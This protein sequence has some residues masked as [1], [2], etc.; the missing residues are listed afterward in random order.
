MCVCVCARV[1]ALFQHVFVIA[2]LRLFVFVRAVLVVSLHEADAG[3][4]L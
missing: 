2:V 4:K 3:Q 1:F